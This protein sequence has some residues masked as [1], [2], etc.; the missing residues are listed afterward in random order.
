[1]PLSLCDGL[2]RWDVG[3]SHPLWVSLWTHRELVNLGK[4]TLFWCAHYHPVQHTFR[5]YPNEQW[6]TLWATTSNDG[7]HQ[8]EVNTVQRFEKV[9]Q[10][11]RCSNYF[12][13]HAGVSHSMLCHCQVWYTLL[14]HGQ[15]LPEMCPMAI[16]ELK[17]LA[18]YWLAIHLSIVLKRHCNP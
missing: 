13:N 5:Q 4:Y 18:K 8:S 1:M 6:K 11:V 3:L 16:R 17:D 14:V 10:E 12:Q 7:L 2:L 15:V 9:V